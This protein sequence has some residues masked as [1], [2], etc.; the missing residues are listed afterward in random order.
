[1][2]LKNNL[3]DSN[4]SNEQNAPR[5]HV[6]YEGEVFFDV[7]DL[8]HRLSINGHNLENEEVEEESDDVV[9]SEPKLKYERYKILGSHILQIHSSTDTSKI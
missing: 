4:E 6:V 2:D 9:N 8:E 7:D 3:S 5:G 1:M